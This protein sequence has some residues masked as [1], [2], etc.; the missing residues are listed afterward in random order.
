MIRISK[1]Q[2]NLRE[3]KM[4]KRIFSMILSFAMIITCGI[5]LTAC[6]KKMDRYLSVIPTDQA[7]KATLNYTWGVD[8]S[9]YEENWK[10]LRKDVTFCETNRTVIYVE[11][12]YTND[13]NHGSDYTRTL[14]YTYNN[15]EGYV[16]SLNGNQWVSYTGSFGDKWSDIYGSYSKP[17]SFVYEMTQ[18]I[19]GRDFPASKKVETTEYLEYDFGRDNEKFRITNNPYHV[20]LYYNFEYGTTFNHK[21]ATL[22]L[23]IP[24]DEIQYLETITPSMIGE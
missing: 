5:C 4:K 6:G 15:N 22:S 1:L 12:S 18:D 7:Y 10:V 19:N 8:G 16:L 2:I 9:N 17:G 21:E 3:D 23:G 11:Y 20:L 24:T 13:K 14:L